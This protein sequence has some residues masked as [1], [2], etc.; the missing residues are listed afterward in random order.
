RRC[1]YGRGSA[2]AGCS[3]PVRCDR[4]EGNTLQAEPGTRCGG[5]SRCSSSQRRFY[6]R[7]PSTTRCP[8]RKNR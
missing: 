8:L 3:R 4:S 1:G 7:A 5:P 2:F 6:C